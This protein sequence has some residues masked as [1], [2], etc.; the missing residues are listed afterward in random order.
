V[1]KSYPPLFSCLLTRLL[2][3]LQQLLLPLVLFRVHTI[4]LLHAFRRQPAHTLSHHSI[5]LRLQNP[6]SGIFADTTAAV[7]IVF[8]DTT[9]AV[10]I[11]FADTAVCVVHG[12]EALKQ[13]EAAAA[14]F[15]TAQQHQQ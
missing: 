2:L 1:L 6:C 4:A 11:V 10:G 15:G 5:N 7:G 13:R 3:L 8:A 9:A 12:V 14:A